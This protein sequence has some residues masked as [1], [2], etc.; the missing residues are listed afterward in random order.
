MSRVGG[1]SFVEMVFSS[2]ALKLNRSQAAGRV[3]TSREYIKLG[4]LVG[5]QVLGAVHL[6]KL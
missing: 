4:G 3:K 1:A 5:T 2:Q 6:E